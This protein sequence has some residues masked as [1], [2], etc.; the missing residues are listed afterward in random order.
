[1]HHFQKL[2]AV[3]SAL[4][5]VL[6]AA[7]V[8]LARAETKSAGPNTV[9]ANGNHIDIRFDPRRSRRVGAC[10]R[11]AHVQF[12]QRALDGKPV[13]ASRTT[14][15]GWMVDGVG[16]RTPDY[17]Q[18]GEI[19]VPRRCINEESNERC[20]GYKRA[21]GSTGLATMADDP[22]PNPVAG[23][24]VADFFTYAFCMDGADRGKW[25]EGV[26]WRYRREPAD[27]TANRLG[28]I[29]IWDAAIVGPPGADQMA[30]LRKHYPSFAAISR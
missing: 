29:A 16:P 12:M 8:R 7:A 14:D 24:Y 28:M 1:M 10:D 21:N 9:T 19:E 2:F 23:V 18:N 15:K 11:I 27:M 17:N 4:L 13:V 20:D 22:Y 30:A 3:S 6:V 5:V 25:Y 26:R